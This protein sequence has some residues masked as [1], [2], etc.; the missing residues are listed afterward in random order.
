MLLLEGLGCEL[1]ATG[2]EVASGEEGGYRAAWE[3]MVRGWVAWLGVGW[4]RRDE[5]TDCIANDTSSC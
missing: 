5:L 3:G 1:G 4:E 2:A